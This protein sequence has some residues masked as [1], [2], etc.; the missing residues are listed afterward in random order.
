[1]VVSLG[2]FW[3]S[4]SIIFYKLIEKNSKFILLI[5]IP[6]FVLSCNFS[7]FIRT[8][9]N[10]SLEM[11][12]YYDYI[13]TIDSNTI[14]IS[15]DLHIELMVAYFK[16]KNKIYLWESNNSD[17]ISSLYRNVNNNADLNKLNEWLNQERSVYF[18]EY[19]YGNDIKGELYNNNYILKKIDRFMVD[20]YYIDFY[21]IELIN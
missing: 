19:I 14:I 17:I 11:K 21:S 18:A 6:L 8:E 13:N 15:N 10:K 3:L 2:I 4:F 7:N 12:K 16:N 20:W 9:E 1:M 5:V